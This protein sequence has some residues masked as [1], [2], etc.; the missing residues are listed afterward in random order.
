MRFWIP[1]IALI[2]LSV[3]ILLGMRRGWRGRSGR[4]A[5]VVG[6]LPEAPVSLGTARTAPFDATYVGSTTAGEWL[7]RIPGQGLGSRAAGSVQ[8]FESGLV[9]VRQGTDDL[10]IPRDRIEAVRFDRGH[11]GKVSSSRRLVVVTWQLAI[12]VESGFLLRNEEQAQELVT[13]LEGAVQQNQQKEA[14]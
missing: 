1:T 9:V 8:L 5:A 2:A 10:Y 6:P 11:A 4:T 3:L 13:A 12:A 7:E 14:G